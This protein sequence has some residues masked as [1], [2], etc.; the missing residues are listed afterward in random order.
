MN[1]IYYHLIEKNLPKILE[2][3]PRILLAIKKMEQISGENTQ[4]L[5][6]NISSIC[7]ENK[8]EYETGRAIGGP[9]SKD[10]AFGLQQK[11]ILDSIVDY[12]M[13]LIV[14][15]IHRSFDGQL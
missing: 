10:K 5:L 14:S 3:P 12:I 9:F 4:T 7:E 15:K 1:D 13:S 11:I 2:S 8:L 6:R